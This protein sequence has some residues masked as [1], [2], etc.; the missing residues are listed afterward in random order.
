MGA[1]HCELVARDGSVAA[2]WT[3]P[4][5]LADEGVRRVYRRM[6]TPYDSAM[7]LRLGVAGPETQGPL[8]RPQGAGS[9]GFDVDHRALFSK[10]TGDDGNEGGGYTAE[11]RTSFGYARVAA[12]FTASTIAD[13]GAIMSAVATFPNTHAW[14]P[15]AASRWDD[16]STGDYIEQAPPE[17]GGRRYPDPVVSFPWQYPRKLAADVGTN[18]AYMKAWDATGSLD[19]LADFRRIGGFPITCAFLADNAREELIAVAYFAA[20][21]LLWP[22]M[23]LRVRYSARLWTIDGRGA[24]VATGTFCR[25]WMQR[26]FEGTAVG[27]DVFRAIP[28][29]ATFPGARRTSTMEDVTPYF[30][31]DAE[32]IDLDPW[33]FTSYDPGPPI[34]PHSVASTGSLSWQWLGDDPVTLGAIA[35]Y[36][37]FAG[38][39]EELAWV[40]ALDSPATLDTTDTLDIPDGI[41]LRLDDA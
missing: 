18:L 37:K 34:I 2:Q 5:T 30:M 38:G 3:V 20:P 1:F 22:G 8:E 19:W 41:V 28:L 29:L 36:G 25:R 6:F 11:M 10:F 27:Y 24:S 17:W 33:T 13:G 12:G 4:N 32:P 14:T 16:P 40:V 26:A 15:E 23:S 31:P 39:A 9:G 35:V 7:D 21:V